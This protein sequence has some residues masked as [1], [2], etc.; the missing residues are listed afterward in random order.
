MGTSRLTPVL[1]LVFGAAATVLALPWS[2][3]MIESRAVM[4]QTQALLPP[5]NT[6][7]IGHPRILD[8][9]DAEEQLT[10]PIAASAD[11]LEQARGLFQTYCAVCH[12]PDG[13][14]VGPVGER[15]RKVPAL[16]DPA[17]QAYPDGLIYSV[18]REGGFNM[19]GYAEALTAQERWA[20]VHFVRSLR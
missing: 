9:I 15:F 17:I 2:R 18:I 13:R 7:A 16:S 4:P 10:N 12:G 11:V 8:R 20:L 6:L 5:P 19:P 1:L 3:D 14:S